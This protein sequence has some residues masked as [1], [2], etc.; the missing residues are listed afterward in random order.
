MF[1]I[2]IVPSQ[3]ETI[4]RARLVEGVRKDLL[5]PAYHGTSERQNMIVYTD[6]GMDVID[7]LDDLGLHTEVFYLNPKAD[8][9]VAMVFRS[10][11]SE[12]P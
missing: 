4:Q 6:F 1:T 12:S 10:Q 7:K 9:H 11:K 5:E 2:P 8:L 3:R